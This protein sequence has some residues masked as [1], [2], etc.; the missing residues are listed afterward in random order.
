[1]TAPEI[2]ESQQNRNTNERMKNTVIYKPI[3][4]GTIST[5]LGKKFQK[6]Q[7]FT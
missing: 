1:M 3:I 4:V 5:G 6:D 2:N 7:S